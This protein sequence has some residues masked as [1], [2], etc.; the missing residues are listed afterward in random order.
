MIDQSPRTTGFAPD[1]LH[2]VARKILRATDADEAQVT[3]DGHTEHLTRFANNH[4]HQNVSERDL[5][6]TIRVAY[7]S[8][9][10]QSVTNDLSDEALARA[11]ES[12][13]ALAKLQPENPEFPGFARPQAVQGVEATIDRTLGFTP[14]DRARV[15]KH[16]TDDA[17]KE[18][19]TAAGSFKT[20]LRQIAIAN[21]H[22]LFAYHQ[23]TLADFN[24][25]VMSDD[26][27]GWASD[28]HLDAGLVDGEALAE[29]AIDKALRSR[30]PQPLDPGV[31]TVVLEEYAVLDMLMYLGMH[32]GA[33][34][35]REG[36]SFLSGRV[37]EQLVHKDISIWDDGHDISGIPAPFDFEGTPKQR[38]EI[39]ERGR[40]GRACY[41]MRTARLDGCS[42]T[43]HYSGGSPFW[44]AGP[45]AWNLFMGAGRNS[46]EEMLESTE[47]GI[48]VT[49]FHY[50][51]M[52]DARK[53]TLTG[54]TRDGTFLI[55]DGKLKT[56]LLNLRFTHAVLDAL[57]DVAM[58]GRKTKLECNYFGG[59]N[60][61]PALK[62]EN[63]RFTGKTSF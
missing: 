52:L 19:L 5:R 38:V 21:S 49:R 18:G 34:E 9:V 33:E 62:I 30:R 20:G 10:G 46:K 35:V 24:T 3:L 17:A 44:G 47:R 15:V 63:F 60:R 6:V 53:T 59:G 54:M 32:L 2:E 22:D 23:H 26:S 1:Q 56:P 55:E 37:G 4:I 45:Q 12:A 31:Y 41:D 57:R 28:T 25:V 29:E 48:W 14:G 61:A 39:F 13:E 40:A 16:V 27:S 7:G 51:N 11:V 50:C 8:K 43:G 42:S 58:V 36:R